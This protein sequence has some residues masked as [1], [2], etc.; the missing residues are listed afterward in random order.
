MASMV[1]NS[2]SVMMVVGSGLNPRRLQRVMIAWSISSYTSCILPGS[3]AYTHDTANL[4][5][6]TR[7]T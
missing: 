6:G 4:P 5:S 3:S 2:K 7:M 1:A